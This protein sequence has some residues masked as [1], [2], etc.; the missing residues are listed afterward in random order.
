[1]KQN[2]D[3]QK[4]YI[5][6]LEAVFTAIDADGSGRINEEELAHVL[7]LPDVHAHL[8][9]LD[10]DVKETAA[11]FHLLDD[12]DGQVT[13][14]EFINGI[15]HCKGQARAIDQVIMQSELRQLAKRS[16]CICSLPSC[17]RRSQDVYVQ[18]R[19]FCMCLSFGV[20]Q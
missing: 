11:L 12:G 19:C 6:K 5:K 20:M 18:P 4:K 7:S 15:I 2:K 3:R 16:G 9:T 13:R 14:D 8:S 17:S 10:V 1:M